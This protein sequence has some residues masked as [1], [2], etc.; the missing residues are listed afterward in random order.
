M[1]KSKGFSLLELLIVVAIILIIATIAIPSLLRSRQTAQE[2]AAVATL[3]TITTAQVLYQSSSSGSF[4][5]LSDLVGA[6]LIDS[7]FGASPAVKSGYAFSITIGGSGTDFTA[8]AT[9][10]SSNSG[11]YAYYAVPDGVIR[12]STSTALA[13][14]GKAGL[15]VQ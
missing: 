1:E 5:D 12:F 11:R 8:T 10:I 13:P 2:T 3:K 6:Q 7:T 14:A 15:P 9:P 4:G